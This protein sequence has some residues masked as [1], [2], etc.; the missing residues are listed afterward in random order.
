MSVQVDEST[1]SLDDLLGHLAD[2]EEL[3]EHEGFTEFAA[4]LSNARVTVLRYPLRFDRQVT[5]SASSVHE[6]PGP[7][8][9][10]SVPRQP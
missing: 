8:P 6:T 7:D 9:S 1:T 2:L 10:A 3:A 5:P 4:I